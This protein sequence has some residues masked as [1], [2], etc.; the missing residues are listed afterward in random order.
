MHI[1]EGVFEYIGWYLPIYIGSD[2]PIGT[3][4]ILEGAFQYILDGTFQ[5]IL[6][7]TFQYIGRYL[8]M[9][10]LEGAFEYIG[11][12]L[13]IYIGSDHPIGTT[14]ILEGTF[15]YI[16]DGT[17]QFCLFVCLCLTARQHN[18]A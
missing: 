4:N 10:I 15:Q 3:M 1:L 2:H 11:W 6:D 5:Y 12:Y 7:G 8:P 14:N 18:K 16:L 17:F 9:Y 13:P